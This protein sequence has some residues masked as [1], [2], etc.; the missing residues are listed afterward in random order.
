MKSE[1]ELQEAT[2][3]SK[4]WALSRWEQIYSPQKKRR[5]QKRSSGKGACFIGDA[6]IL[7]SPKLIVVQA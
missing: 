5:I 4:L 3:T 7:Q 6:T 2:R 1:S